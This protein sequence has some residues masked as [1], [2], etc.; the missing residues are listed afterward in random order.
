[1]G[2][3][4]ASLD[5]QMRRMHALGEM[6][7]SDFFGSFICRTKPCP[8]SFVF[9]ASHCNSDL[10]HR[11]LWTNGGMSCT[12]MLCN[13]NRLKALRNITAPA[14]L[15]VG[16]Y[17]LADPADVRAMADTMQHGTFVEFHNCGHAE[18]IDAPSAFVKSFSAWIQQVF[19]H[20][21]AGLNK[22]SWGPVS[23]P[24]CAAWIS[25]ACLLATLI[26]LSVTLCRK[27]KTEKL[28]IAKRSPLLSSCIS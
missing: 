22:T 14:L 27:A 13:W 4:P 5:A 3:F 28:G 21:E 12:G 6:N 10:N 9:A 23:H 1:M 24:F 2:G 11:L 15:I 8:P 7:V 17:D 20:K 19:L 25:M 16:D 18:W 26:F